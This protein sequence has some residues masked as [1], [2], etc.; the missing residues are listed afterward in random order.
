M[1]K[2]KVVFTGGGTGGHVYPNI[3]IYE[4]IKE[5][6][7]E[8]S[9][10][11]VGTKS[12]AE[13]RI[14]KNFSQPIDF[15]HILSRGIPQN[16]KS[17][18][19]IVALFYILMGMIKS[20]FILRNFKPDIVIGS[21]G[22]VAAP[23]LLAAAVL[24]LKVFIHEQ[25]AVPGRLNRYIAKFSNRIGV[26]F[27]STSRF[28]PEHKVSVT[29]YPLRKSIRSKKE[30]NI[31]ETLKIPENNQVLF[32]CGG[33]SGARTINNAIAEIIPALLGIDRLS[34]IISTGRGYSKEYRAFDDTVN[35]F[36]KIGIP[37]EIEGKL[38][39]KE[40]FDNIDEIYSISDLIVSRAGAG[41]L[42]EITT[43]GIP[44]ILIPK[45]DLPGDHQ[46]LN[47]LEVQKI[48]GARIV[49]EDVVRKNDKRIISVPEI[50]LL[51]VIKDLIS[52][53]QTLDQMKKNL[54]KL[55][56]RD[57]TELILNEIDQIVT[58]EK[59]VEEKQ[60]KIFY[61][62]SEGNEKSF[63]LIF[64]STTLGNSFLSDIYLEE[65]EN[66]VLFK[67]KNINKGSTLILKRIKGKIVLNGEEIKD[68]CEIREGDRIEL[69]NHSYI[70]KS[71]LEKI[72]EV[73]LEKSTASKIWGSSFGIMISRIGGFF[74]EVVMAAIFGAGKAMSIFAV[75]LTI[76]N[77]MRR[78]V[79]E[80]ALENAFL[81]IF[82]RFFH[83]SSRKKTWESTSSIINVTLFL[84]FTFT[85]LGIL[86]T[87]LIIKS[88]FPAFIEK[89]M[90]NETINMTR[91][92]FPYLFLVTVAAILATFLKGFNRFGIAEA[93]AIFFSIGTISGILVLHS[94]SGI[95]SLAIGVLLGGIMQ[96]GF[97]FPFVAKIFR[98]KSLQFFYKPVINFTSTSNKK[99]YSQIGP[100]TLDVFLSNTSEIVAQILASALRVGAIAYLYFARTIF[101]LPFAIISQA[102]NSVILKEF[103]DS[104]ALFSKDKAKKLFI[105]GIKTNL[106]LLMPISIFMIILAEPLVSIIL[107][108]GQ[109][110]TS[111][112]ISTSYALQ[113]YAVGLIGWGIHSFTV[114][115]F[116]ARMDIKT[117]MIL[118]F[119]MLAANISLCLVLVK[120]SLDYAGLALATSIS[121]LIFS[122]I[123]IV[124]LK[125]RLAREDIIISY[126]KILL[127]FGKT[128]F[129][130]LLMVIVLVET[131]FIFNKIQFKSRVLEDIVL[132]ISMVFIGTAIYFLSSLLMKNTEI[133]ILRKT[134]RK[135][136]S[137]IPLSML[138]PFGFFKKV[139][140]DPQKFRDNYLYKINIYL[141]SQK[142]EI[143]NIGVKLIGLFNQVSKSEY[144]F[145]ILKS[146]TEKGFIKRNA[147]VS[148]QQLNIWNPELKALVYKLLTDTYYEVRVAAIN[149]ITHCMTIED[150]AYFK[151]SIYKKLKHS[152]I[153]EK[154]ACLKL[155]GKFG[156][157]DDVEK[158]GHFCLSSNSLIREELLETFFSLYKRKILSKIETKDYLDRI[159]ITSNNLN[160]E[161]RLKS[162]LKKIYKELDKK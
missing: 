19:T 81:P 12:G 2:L 11:Y 87:P 147:L 128:L 150:Y 144:L 15:V 161:F 80:N 53:L 137:Q 112:V 103:S 136:R 44:S 159:L 23:V 52:D 123:R 74:R 3:A 124:V 141:S 132:L 143:R 22:Y 78:I 107:G 90:L 145:D 56:K 76:S 67:I 154:M 126:K 51:K 99:Y 4:A 148:L 157:K 13:N 25:N 37:S 155:I 28:F 93:S 6:Y 95:Y 127:S 30:N 36:Q 101:R 57:S 35:I 120:T 160:P 63:E 125:K 77:F 138:S 71:Y 38:I 8:S 89:G 70:L 134:F 86:F 62:Q 66:D 100:I 82:L 110:N 106:F 140:A 24:K 34:I 117:S 91:L 58:I 7:P 26:S 146:K 48:G 39:V 118:N 68:W 75:G 113:F 50:T 133:L 1:Q 54:Q 49:Y 96:I 61:L 72:E 104:I 92:M 151:D 46:I 45:I 33:S 55:D 10:L 115:I 17:L 149:Y 60:I 85:I 158:L 69:V 111:N 162:I 116:S 94:I 97:L 142:W 131:K 14:I 139:S 32:V 20:F 109:F 83:R 105:D 47:A 108:R 18:K 43:V 121:Y 42:K 41:S 40:Y 130:S 122:V 88:L 27:L 156:G 16:I 114:R 65:L 152:G 64:D 59:K 5:K 21:G 9:F 73:Y 79:A 31:K 135:K 29:G 153:E 84:S 98:N 102:I 129:A 119:F